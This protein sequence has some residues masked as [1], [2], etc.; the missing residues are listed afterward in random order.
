MRW[1]FWYLRS[2]FC[3]HVWQTAEQAYTTWRRPDIEDR[4]LAPEV[5]RVGERHIIR[6]S[7]TCKKCGWHRSYSKFGI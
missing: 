5:E 3:K 7:A 2:L 6:V 1:I 4:I